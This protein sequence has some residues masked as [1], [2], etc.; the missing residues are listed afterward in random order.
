M[1][2]KATCPLGSE[3]EVAKDGYIERCKWYTE[4]QMIN[5]QTGEKVERWDCAIVW[6]PILQMEVA[7]KI[8]F[9]GDMAVNVRNEIH[10][11]SKISSLNASRVA[12][13]IENAEKAGSKKVISGRS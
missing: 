7:Q 11:H 6:A 2:I 3:C 8:S 4:V 10:D 1:D 9:V 13:A 5:S 12:G